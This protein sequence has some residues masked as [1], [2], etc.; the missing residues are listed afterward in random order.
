MEYEILDFIEEDY[1]IISK[2]INSEYRKDLKNVLAFKKTNTFLFIKEKKK[3]IIKEKTNILN[4]IEALKNFSLNEVT[5]F[6]DFLKDLKI[7]RSFLFN[8]FIN[9]NTSFFYLLDKT[10]L[11]RDIKSNTSRFAGDFD[12]KLI[13]EECYYN[14]N[15]NYEQLVEILKRQISRKYVKE[16]FKNVFMLQTQKTFEYLYLDE[17]PNFFL[18][19]KQKAL[20]ELNN[21][22]S[23]HNTNKWINKKEYKDFNL[24]EKNNFIYFDFHKKEVITNNDLY[25]LPNIKFNDI[26]EKF[27]GVYK[28]YYIFIKYYINKYEIKIYTKNGLIKNQEFSSREI[29]RGSNYDFIDYKK[30]I[31]NFIKTNHL[32]L[33][34]Y[35]FYNK[36]AYRINND[37]IKEVKTKLEDYSYIYGIVKK[38]EEKEN[39]IGIRYKQEI[40]IIKTDSKFNYV[41]SGNKIENIIENNL[42]ELEKESKKNEFFLNI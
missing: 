34:H 6:L 30:I 13:L 19:E 14:S 38:K 16:I 21:R 25:L 39:F 17:N 37:Y 32:E 27:L 5:N 33:I 35:E 23:F 1:K 29:Q 18:S 3:L 4:L 22:I 10:I 15:I 7:K 9:N 31:D 42:N 8:C 41:V 36:Y 2:F 20:I 26:Q 40:Y 24:Y 11:I 12:V 28:D